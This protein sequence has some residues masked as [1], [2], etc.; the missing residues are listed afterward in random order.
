MFSSQFS[1]LDSSVIPLLEGPSSNL[2]AQ[3]PNESQESVDDTEIGHFC[4]PETSNIKYQPSTKY[5]N[6]GF[7]EFMMQ[8]SK[9]SIKAEISEAVSDTSL[10]KE[11]VNNSSFIF[12]I[13]FQT[14]TFMMSV[15]IA[16]LIAWII[17]SKGRK[18]VRMRDS[19][20]SH[21][22]VCFFQLLLI[23]GG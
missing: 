22:N 5:S 6:E 7:S 8:L 3:D 14:T 2:I 17:T 1:L 16:A 11:S 10:P 23:L 18:E 13:I 21:F 19:V 4:L 12:N 15:I 20:N 9:N